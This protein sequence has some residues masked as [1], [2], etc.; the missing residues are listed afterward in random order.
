MQHIAF[1]GLSSNLPPCAHR[2]GGPEVNLDLGLAKIAEKTSILALSRRYLTA[3]LGVSEPMPDFFNQVVKIAW[4]GDAPELLQF[5]LAIE[6]ELGRERSYD[7][8]RGP[9]ARTL[10]LDL[11]LF[12]AEVWQLPELTVPHPRM[13]ERAFVLVPLLDIWQRDD[14]LPNTETPGK[15]LENCLNRLAWSLDNQYIVQS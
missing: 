2:R 10:D 11:L 6:D 15:Y 3:P 4:Q 13:F 7:K 1:V 14:V 8:S 9:L 12:D 5:L